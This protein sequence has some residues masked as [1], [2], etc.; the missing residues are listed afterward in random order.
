MI[1]SAHM[2]TAGFD[3]VAIWVLSA[4]AIVTLVFT[5]LWVIVPKT[6]VEDWVTMTVLGGITVTL[7]AAVAFLAFIYPHK[8][9]ILDKGK[10]EVSTAVEE[11]QKICTIDTLEFRCEIKQVGK[12]KYEVWG[13]E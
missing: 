12:N 13:K 4:M 10:Q 11:G 9:L 6:R 7:I 2:G 1:G 3:A 8:A 5:V